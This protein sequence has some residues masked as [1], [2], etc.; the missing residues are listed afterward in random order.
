MEA[1]KKVINVLNDLIMIN[2]DRTEG[3]NQAAESLNEGNDDLL[4]L[5]DRFKKQSAEF[6]S[7]L[8]NEVQQAGGEVSDGT[9]VSGK[10]HRGWMEFKASMSGDKRHNVLESCEAGEDAAQKAYA[11]ALTEDLPGNIRQMIADQKNTLKRAHDEVKALRD[12]GK[13]HA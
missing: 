8:R 2:N 3:Y 12:S 9:T 10:L 4:S 5:F 11:Q 1:Q 6:S 13:V 7:R